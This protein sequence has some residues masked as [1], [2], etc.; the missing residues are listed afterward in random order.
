MHE[1]EKRILS[2]FNKSTYEAFVKCI[3][4]NSYD[5]QVE[6]FISSDKLSMP[7]FVRYQEDGIYELY[8]H[9]YLTNFYFLNQNNIQRKFVTPEIKKSVAQIIKNYI[10]NPVRDWRTHHFGKIFLMTNLY[11][12]SEND[13]EEFFSL[14]EKMVNPKLSYGIGSIDTFFKEKSE[15]VNSYLRSFFRTSYDG[16]VLCVGKDH[17]E[18]RAYF[19]E[20][21]LS[22]GIMHASKLP[23]ES[24]VTTNIIN[25]FYL[26][27]ELNNVIN[28]G[29]EHMIEE[30][31]KE[32]YATVLGKQY[33]RIETQIWLKFPDLD[34]GNRNRRLDVFAHNSIRD[35]WELFELKPDLDII[36][37][38]RGVP[39][40]TKAVYKA[41]TQSK[42]YYR[43]L[44]QDTVKQKLK[45]E[46]IEYFEPVISIVMGK[47]PQL[48]KE[49]WQ[50][51]LNEHRDINLL[52]YDNIIQEM[53]LNLTD[54]LQFI[55][56]K[57]SL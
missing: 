9:H 48:T 38:T 3:L 50:W 4:S 56:T 51:L 44:Q 11:N 43:L 25:Q 16:I 19:T 7:Y 35:D 57:Q 17:V 46:G 54:K 32:N 23:L 15:E 6:G 18:A 22:S 21:I 28:S 30:F 1:L 42:N 49:K 8:E 33:D 20:N 36:T 29:D 24:I 53:K 34:I 31:I 12:F 41:I 52:T 2:T 40:F 55:D 10:E 45:L 47:A 26:I 27:E 37:E 5:E 39:T 13:Y 14:L